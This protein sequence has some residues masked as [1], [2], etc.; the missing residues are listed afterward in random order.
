MPYLE[1]LLNLKAQIKSLDEQIN[2]MMPDGIVEALE[3]LGG[4]TNS[5]AVHQ[6]KKGKIIV[7]F[8]KKVD[9]DHPELKKLKSRIDD[10]REYLA[11]KYSATLNALSDRIA[12]LQQE[13]TD[14]R[15]KQEAIVTS[16]SLDILLQEY[17]GLKQDL[18]WLNP[19]LAFYLK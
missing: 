9:L 11:D 12:Q 18:Q 4:D 5:R 6:S 8:H 14:L 3:I 2:L 17:Q 10:E 15:A 1:D 13:I 19:V 16:E 7:R